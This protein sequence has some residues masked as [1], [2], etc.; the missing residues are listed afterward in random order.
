MIS[1]AEEERRAAAGE[2]RNEKYLA[3]L[4]LELKEVQELGTANDLVS[5]LTK[6]SAQASWKCDFP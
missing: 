3:A 4:A 6:W 5:E 2:V 1:K